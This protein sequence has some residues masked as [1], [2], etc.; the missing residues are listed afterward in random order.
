MPRPQILL[1]TDFNRTLPARLLADSFGR[2]RVSAHGAVNRR[3]EATKMTIEITLGDCVE[4]IEQFYVWDEADDLLR[5]LLAVEM[6]PEVIRMYGHDIVTKRRSENTAWIISTIP[7]Q[8]SRRSGLRSCFQSSG[9][10]NPLPDGLTA[11]WCRCIRTARPVLG[12]TR[13]KGNR[14][15]SRR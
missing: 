10:W 13:T 5:A 9:A 14:K 4:Y 1:Q 7:R 12:G 3:V 2:A 8:R 15:S 11:G 6:A